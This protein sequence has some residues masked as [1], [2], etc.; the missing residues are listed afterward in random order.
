MARALVWHTKVRNRMSG[1]LGTI[2]GILAGGL[3]RRTN[4]GTK[5]KETLDVLFHVLANGLV[6]WTKCG[7]DTRE[8]RYHFRWFG[9]W[10]GPMDQGTRCPVLLQMFVFEWILKFVAW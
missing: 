6:M 1:D 9:L 4:A 10:I 2:P 5:T 8:T 7:Q 3:V